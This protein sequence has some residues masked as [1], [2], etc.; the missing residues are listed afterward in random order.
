MIHNPDIAVRTKLSSNARKAVLFEK[1]ESSA[2]PFI[3]NFLGITDGSEAFRLHKEYRGNIV[4]LMY[5]AL[6]EWFAYPEVRKPFIGE[7]YFLP[8]FSLSLD[9][10]RITG[11]EGEKLL[12][13]VPGVL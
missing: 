13:A 8:A 6:T 11:F 9:L 1:L 7:T 5:R 12:S 4:G 2:Q 10:F 3:F